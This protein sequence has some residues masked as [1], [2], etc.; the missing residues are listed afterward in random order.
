[1]QRSHANPFPVVIGF[2]LLIAALLLLGPAAAHSKAAQCGGADKPAYSM[3][4]SE[5]AKATLCLLNKERSSH[6]MKPLR[7]DKHQEKAASKHNRVMLK[8]NCFSHLCPGEKDLVARIAS[9]GYLPCT[10]TW[11]VAE[12]LAWGE[13]SKATPA[14]VVDAWM[15]SADHRVNILNPKYEEIGIA[16]DDGSPEGG[17]PASTYTTDFGFKD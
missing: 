5:A 13:S 2:A 3:S 17:G 10:C 8:K 1:M 6:G 15:G 14:S 7:F 16:I 9:T 4:D 11:G 12:N